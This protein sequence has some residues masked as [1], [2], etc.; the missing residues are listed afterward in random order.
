MDISVSFPSDGQIR[1]KS[2]YLFADPTGDHCRRFVERVLVADE[3]DSVTIRGGRGI[4]GTSEADIHYRPDVCSR[5]QVV[6][7]IYARLAG[8][9]GAEVPTNGYHTANGPANG[10][11]NGNGHANGHAQAAKPHATTAAR[12]LRAGFDF[13]QI[14]DLM[15]A[16]VAPRV[17]GNV[18]DWEILHEI[19]GRL[20]LKN[21]R[22]HRQ[23]D[24]CGAIERELMSVLGIDNYK[25]SPTTGSVLIQY[26]R[27]QLNREQIVEILDSA[28]AQAEA[29]TG[30]D[31]ADLQL[32]LCT[33][34]LPLAAVA[35]FVAPPLIPLA[36]G[37]FLYT[38]IPTF[39][40]AKRSA[41][42]RRSGS[43][44]TFS[45]RSWSSA[46]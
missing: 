44:W 1:L 33:A 21:E 15:K 16:S 7:A 41:C 2:R 24:L 17:K 19:P 40:G 37:L 38:S 45:T 35:Q 13:G 9:D 34:S 5:A 39:Q 6:A 28:L 11:G 27:K 32:A 43:A 3:V 25:T 8:G 46:A 30:R 26:D 42:S 22:L 23:K 4:L 18:S 29:P 31:K 10:N 12:G 14:R 20:R 36:A